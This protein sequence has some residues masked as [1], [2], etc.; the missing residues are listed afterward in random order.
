LG[1]PFDWERA[2][3]AI[4]DAIDRDILA[5]LKEDGRMSSSEM[6][7]RL[8]GAVSERSVRYRIERL[9][10]SGV[11]RVTAVLNPQA[12]GYTTVGDVLIDVAPGQL[13]EVAAQ[14]V[15]LGQVTYVGGVVGD[16]DLDV[17]VVA[18]D[19]EDLVRVSNEVIGSIPGVTRVRT[20]IIPWKLKET[21]DWHLPAEPAEEGAAMA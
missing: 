7:R 12:L 11:L 13:Q 21:C 20:L 9:R 1:N 17:Q 8:P 15:Q 19:N 2:V 6:A 3:A 14:L 5:F 16:G 10:K 18:R 4:L